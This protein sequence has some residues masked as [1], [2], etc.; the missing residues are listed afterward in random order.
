MK[1]IPGQSSYVYGHTVTAVAHHPQQ[2]N[3]SVGLEGRQSGI[4]EESLQEK[5]KKKR[6]GLEP[7]IEENRK[8]G[9]V[10][11]RWGQASIMQKTSF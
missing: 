9:G 5:K 2:M 3:G 6:E 11:A 8:A 7:E 4:S 10:E 1:R